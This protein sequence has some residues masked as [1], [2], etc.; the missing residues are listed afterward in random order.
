MTF[1]DL[2]EAVR[3]WAGGVAVWV[4]VIAAAFAVDTAVR[5]FKRW[6]DTGELP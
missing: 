1:D 2:L 3:V 6:H 4:L 5:L